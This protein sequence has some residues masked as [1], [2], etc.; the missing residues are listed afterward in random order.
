MKG[1]GEG[2]VWSTRLD[3]GTVSS[4]KVKGEK[5][6]SSKVKTLAPV[7]VE[8][9]NNAIEFVEKVV[10]ISR[11]QQA[12]EAMLDRDGEGT[13]IFDRK[14]LGVFI[15]WVSTDV[16]KEE[17]DTL[18]ASGLTMKDVGGKLSSK[19]RQWFFEQEML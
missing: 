12:A 15:K 6:Q 9:V 7:D 5:H 18:L 14:F 10:T 3:D 19:S 8:K 1:V 17:A 11:L 13:P 4:F 2:V 16:L